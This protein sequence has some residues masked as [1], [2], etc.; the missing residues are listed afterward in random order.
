MVST[1]TGSGELVKER[2][3]G[4]VARR[5]RGGGSGSPAPAAALPPAPAPARPLPASEANDMLLYVT[6]AELPTWLRRSIA[7][8]VIALMLGIDI[9]ESETVP[10]RLIM[11]A[12][13][14]YHEPERLIRPTAQVAE[15]CALFPVTV[16]SGQDGDELLDMLDRCPKEVLDFVRE[17]LGMFVEVQKRV[18]SFVAVRSDSTR[19]ECSGITRAKDP[20]QQLLDWADSMGG[21]LCGSWQRLA[22]V[23]QRK[24]EREAERYVVR[25]RAEGMTVK[26]IEVYAL[27]PR[28]AA[29]A[30]A[31]KLRLVAAF[32][33]RIDRL[34]A[35]AKL[36]GMAQEF[37]VEEFYTDGE[38][39]DALKQLTPEQL[40]QHT[41]VRSR[42]AVV[43][44]DDA[45][46]LSQMR[47]DWLRHPIASLHSWR[48][49]RRTPLP[50]YA[51][52]NSR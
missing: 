51:A 46:L 44:Q 40:H 49:E 2:G 13:P 16:E 4:N 17:G 48:D 39:R 20:T 33:Q 24:V 43:T 42:S 23:N 38:V 18:W 8:S 47:R 10:P 45:R 29:L 1:Q 25:L 50:V 30:V 3:A 36:G 11:H 26:E 6:A 31:Q 41:Q 37:A 14:V 27:D 5:S 35:R 22:A 12:W 19:A 7:S 28:H 9:E 34:T 15:C 32:R 21:R 52:R